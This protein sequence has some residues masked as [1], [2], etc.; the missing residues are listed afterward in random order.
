MVFLD[1]L[2]FLRL[3]PLCTRLESLEITH[4]LTLGLKLRGSILCILLY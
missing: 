4:F 3:F 2:L 1:H